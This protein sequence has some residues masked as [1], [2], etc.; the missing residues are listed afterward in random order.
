MRGAGRL[1]DLF[2]AV[3]SS[4]VAYPAAGFPELARRSG[5]RLV[6]LNRD[7]TPLDALAVLVLQAEIGPT[8]SVAGCNDRLLSDRPSSWPL[9]V[10][11]SWCVL[12]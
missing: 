5:G 12:R 2:L 9:G 8:L 1:R 6:I 7:P 3:G 4:L 11:F 10:A